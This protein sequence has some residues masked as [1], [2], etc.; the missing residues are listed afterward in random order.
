LLASAATSFS[1]LRL[2][3]GFRV[4]GRASGL[5][6]LRADAGC[7]FRSL[8]R[9]PRACPCGS[10]RADPGSPGSAVT[11]VTSSLPLD[12]RPA[13]RAGAGP[14]EL[15]LV[16][17]RL[18][19]RGLGI[20]LAFTV[21]PPGETESLCRIRDSRPRVLRRARR[22]RLASF[23]SASSSFRPGSGIAPLTRPC[24]FAQMV[25]HLHVSSGPPVDC[26]LRDA[27][28]RP[29]TVSGAE[30]LAS[31]VGVAAF[32]SEIGCRPIPRAACVVLHHPGRAPLPCPGIAPDFPSWGS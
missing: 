30:E 7:S 15:R 2:S 21:T 24:R 16:G 8:S 18:D 1:S 25:T 17:L 12:S 14:V 31:C 26:L 5:P 22:A 23:S 20:P 29:S 19:R 9:G 27:K 6:P 28:D 32:A 4:V 10:L 11:C 3:R 13:G